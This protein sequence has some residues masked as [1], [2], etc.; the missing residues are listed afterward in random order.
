MT[1]TRLVA[2]RQSRVRDRAAGGPAAFISQLRFC[3]PT[4]G[5]RNRA[6]RC[7][8][9]STGIATGGF[10]EALKDAP[11]LSL[12]C[13]GIH[14]GHGVCMSPNRTPCP[15]HWTL[16]AGPRRKSSAEACSSSPH[17][18]ARR[19]KEP[20]SLCVNKPFSIRRG[21]SCLT[22]PRAQSS[23]SAVAIAVRVSWTRLS[24]ACGRRRQPWPERCVGAID[25]STAP[26]P[27]LERCRS[28][29]LFAIG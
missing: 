13:P 6:R 3:R 26:S 28:G 16:G 21:A 25:S 4:C 17:P 18:P 2:I 11:G 22:V 14:L 8:R 5:T 9:S 1:G 29:Y 7:W 23:L 12:T 15:R 20:A 10:S 19:R 27:G 24:Q